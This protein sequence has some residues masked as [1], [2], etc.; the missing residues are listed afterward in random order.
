MGNFLRHT[1]FLR[2]K[3]GFSIAELVIVMGLVGIITAIALAYNNT[4]NQTISLYTEQA[5][6]AG[7]LTRAKTLTL[8][9]R[10]EGGDAAPCAYGVR[11][12][13]SSYAIYAVSLLPDGTC[14]P[15]ESGSD[16][17]NFTLSPGIAI[18]DSPERVVFEAPYLTAPLNG[19]ITLEVSGSDLEVEIEVD[20]GGGI[21]TR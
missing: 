12:S 20:A 17:E 3:K 14:N 4:S 10:S 9:R 7:I 16:V 1:R 21:T 11:F 2:D 13:A 8:Q 18:Q 6:I 15:V 5:K 19:V